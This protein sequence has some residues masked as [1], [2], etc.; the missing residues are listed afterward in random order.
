KSLPSRLASGLMAKAGLEPSLSFADLDRGRR[1]ALL[2]VL[3]RF[4]LP[5]SGHCGWDEAEVTGGG[6]ALEEVRPDTLESRLHPG[7]HFAG[8]VL[9]AFGPVGGYNLYWAWLSGFTPARAGRS[10]GRK[11]VELRSPGRGGI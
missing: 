2:N 11:S 1:R 6:V 5:V 3:V 9:D 7:L 8:E 10:H 4:P